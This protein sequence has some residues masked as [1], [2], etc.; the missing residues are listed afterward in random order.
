LISST[1]DFMCDMLELHSLFR[2]DPLSFFL[3]REKTFPVHPV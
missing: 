3:E 2:Q 1:N